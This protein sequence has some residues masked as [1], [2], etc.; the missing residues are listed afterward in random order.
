MAIQ[1]FRSAHFIDD[2]PC[3]YCHT[4]YIV[5]IRLRVKSTHLRLGCSTWVTLCFVMLIC[6]S[7]CICIESKELASPYSS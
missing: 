6:I 7:L 4:T 3:Q 1:N 2:R 5:T